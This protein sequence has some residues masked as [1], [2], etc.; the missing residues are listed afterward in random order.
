M[1]RSRA[2]LAGPLFSLLMWPMGSYS[3]LAATV[4][5]FLLRR[6]HVAVETIAELSALIQIA[7]VWHFLWTPITDTLFRRR[8]WYLWLC[9][10]TAV[11]SGIAMLA[12]VPDRLRVFTI[13]I[14]LA[15]VFS[16]PA[17][18]V[19]GAL[20]AASVPNAHRGWV[21]GFSEAGN[22]GGGAM[23]A[24][25]LMWLALRLPA[26][27]YACAVALVIAT[28]SLIAFAIEEPRSAP[29][30]SFVDS[31]HSLGREI[32]GA[33]RSWRVF[34]GFLFFTSPL[35]CVAALD[36]ISAIGSDFHAPEATTIWVTGFASGFCIAI[37][38]IAYGWCCDRM[39][40]RTAYL[41]AG[42]ANCGTA[43]A[44]LLAPAS[45]FTYAAGCL[46][47]SATAGFCFTAASTLSLEIIG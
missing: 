36:L 38:S 24:G 12:P 30:R 9:S 16:Y 22:L 20:K 46:A 45:P 40:R 27:A 31:L 6:A 28:P 33:L 17:N 1:R 14:F 13:A 18:S 47:Y 41:A 44:M 7:A 26:A 37:G 10:M 32:R 43:L 21:S 2:Y 5:P 34:E 39:E 19:L 23:A 35:G 3:A 25:V 15:G 42:L 29:R 8:T 4:I 11:A